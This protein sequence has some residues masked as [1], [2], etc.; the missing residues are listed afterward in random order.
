MPPNSSPASVV[1]DVLHRHPSLLN[2]AQRGSRTIKGYPTTQ[3]GT[4]NIKVPNLADYEVFLTL[5]DR[6]GQVFKMDANNVVTIPAIQMRY[7]VGCVAVL[8]PGIGQPPPPVIE[9]EFKHK[10][11][12]LELDRKNPASIDVLKDH[13]DGIYEMNWRRFSVRAPS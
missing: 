6:T 4:I 11:S 5:N 3:D 2:V 10:N 12:L 9:A 1:L 13:G 8:I 7:D